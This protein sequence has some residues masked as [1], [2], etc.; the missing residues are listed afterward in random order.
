[1]VFLSTEQIFGAGNEETG[2]P[3]AVRHRLDR[4]VG[5]NGFQPVTDR[6]VVGQPETAKEWSNGPP[7]R[8]RFAVERERPD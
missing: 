2:F 5:G 3:G 4:F 1:M 7:E 6:A 8:V